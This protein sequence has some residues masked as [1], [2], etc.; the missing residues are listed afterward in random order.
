MRQA[1]AV[2]VDFGMTEAGVA[3][4][5][6]ALAAWRGARLVGCASFPSAQSVNTD[7]A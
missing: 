1:A 7:N 3:E 6:A 2:L 4:M 5:R